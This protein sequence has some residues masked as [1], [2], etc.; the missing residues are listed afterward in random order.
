M[1]G[2]L[3]PSC[4][5]EILHSLFF[6]SNS[7]KYSLHAEGFSGTAGRTS[8]LTHTGSQFSTKD[9]DNDRCTCKCAQL[10]SGGTAL[11]SPTPVSVC[12]SL[13]PVLLNISIHPLINVLKC[14]S[15]S[16]CTNIKLLLTYSCTFGCYISRAWINSDFFLELCGTLPP[17]DGGLRRAARPTWTAYIT[18]PPPARST[19]TVSSGTTGRVRIWWLPWQPWWCAQQT[20]DSSSQVSK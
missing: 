8:S 20:S 9:R 12:L 13:W 3:R 2:S 10:A 7:S 17:Q 14:I 1:N 5:A 15:F 6:F 18:L 11:Q 19:T 4:F 16:L